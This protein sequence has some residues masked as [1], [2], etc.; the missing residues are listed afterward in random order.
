MVSRCSIC[1]EEE[2]ERK[3]KEMHSVE[4]WVW[5]V[6]LPTTRYGSNKKRF[7]RANIEP[8]ACLIDYPGIQASRIT[9]RGRQLTIYRSWDDTW[10]H[11]DT[12]WTTDYASATRYARRRAESQRTV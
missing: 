12:T 6:G 10:N 2:A 4:A 7:R 8:L 11:H 5:E 1:P 9:I 3:V